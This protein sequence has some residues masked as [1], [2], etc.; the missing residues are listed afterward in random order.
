MSKKLPFTK[1]EKAAARL[2]LVVDTVR[3]G[4]RR[5]K[6]ADQMLKEAKEGA[7]REGCDVKAILRVLAEEELPEAEWAKLSEDRLKAAH[8]FEDTRAAYDRAFEETPI[9][10][11]IE[12]Q[13][14]G[15]LED[16]KAPSPPAAAP[17]TLQ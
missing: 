6:E 3:R 4:L 14:S 15:A 16:K 10:R 9:E 11:A 12:L 13:R 17:R 8:D 1:D 5:K 7:K 2:A